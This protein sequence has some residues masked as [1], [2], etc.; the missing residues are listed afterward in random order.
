MG[1]GNAKRRKKKKRILG[2]VSADLRARGGMSLHLVVSR[3][4]AG[5]Q[6]S[7][8][9][10]WQAVGFASVWFLLNKR[11]RQCRAGWDWPQRAAMETRPPC[12]FLLTTDIGSGFARDHRRFAFP[13][14]TPQ[15]LFHEWDFNDYGKTLRIRWVYEPRRR[16]PMSLVRWTSVCK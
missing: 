4:I 7:G 12:G 3:F 11:L 2:W 5:P 1:S 16:C 13:Y 8:P 10:P 6:S 15:F 9:G 14:L